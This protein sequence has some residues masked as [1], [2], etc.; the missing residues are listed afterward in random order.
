MTG[1]A[2]KRND[3]QSFKS[4][5]LHE[6]V[7][8]RVSE[9][10][11]QYPA[12]E[13][14]APEV[15]VD[16]G[17]EMKTEIPASSAA[18]AA[19]SPSLAVSQSDPASAQF[20]VKEKIGEGGMG[21][22]YKAE[23]SNNGNSVAVKMLHTNLVSDK[24][25]LRRFE[26]EAAAIGQLTH[27]NIVQVYGF[28][29][30]KD[31]PHL[32]MEY[33][34]GC[35]LAEI[36]RHDRTVSVPRVI[37]W[38]IQICSA[39]KHAHEKGIVHRDLKPSNIL[40]KE[41]SSG[42]Q[43]KLVDFG[44]AKLIP[45]NGS[46]TELTQTGEVFG[47]PNY[48][49]PEQCMGKPV[50]ARTDIYS[51]GCI[52]YEAL[53]GKNLFA[54]D[55]SVQYLIHH[56]NSP[57]A[58]QLANLRKFGAPASL[59]AVLEKMLQKDP[60]KRYQT[61]AEVEEEFK[62]LAAGKSSAAAQNQLLGRVAVAG[63]AVAV[64]AIGSFGASKLPTAPG[65]GNAA[66]L[67]TSSKPQFGIF[68][69]SAEAKLQRLVQAHKDNWAYLTGPGRHDRS[70][71]DRHNQEY[72]ELSE[73]LRRE[74]S[75]MGPAAIPALL[76]YVTDR[77][78]SNDVNGILMEIGK[79]AVQPSID[80][81]RSHPR[82]YPKIAN[83]FWKIGKPACDRLAEM[84]VSNP[85]DRALAAS[86]L[87]SRFNRDHRFDGVFIGPSGRTEKVISS[88]SQKSLVEAL[89]VEKDNEVRTNLIL[90]LRNVEEPSATTCD[91]LIKL[92]KSES[93]EDAKAAA[94]GTM[95]YWANRVSGEVSTRLTTALAKILM[96]D[97]A[98]DARIAAA[99]GLGSVTRTTPEIIAALRGAK[100][101]PSDSVHQAAVV[102]L[103]KLALYDD[104]LLPDLID[105]LK[106]SSRQSVAAALSTVRQLG[107]KAVG[108]VSAI[109]KVRP[110]NGNWQVIE[111][112]AATQSDTKEVQEMML[113]VLEQT[114][115]MRDFVQRRSAI[116]YFKSLGE[117]G[118]LAVPVL[119]RLAES[120]RS[121]N[122]YEAR[123]ALKA[124]TG[125]IVQN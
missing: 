52:I 123:E 81:L 46:V 113:S 65:S 73:R 40:I 95:A 64:V 47:S 125:E 15:F 23:L 71:R 55:N 110:T 22:V 87:A 16:S 19:I 26:K 62:K 56:I 99:E 102:A 79:P 114:D 105:A 86:I 29:A 88:S 31:N 101:D 48:M 120:G 37:D 89:N 59:V 41:S 118:K 92:A 44:I 21:A 33:V 109:L 1:D 85:Q 108:A 76:Q 91:A 70:D 122:R 5:E 72:R 69:D 116:N 54:A 10:E 49:S 80:W 3:A 107:P 9:S 39:I 32:V 12:P 24:V 18:A 68:G 42:D 61:A 96:H 115:E 13:P 11:A 17:T 2:D 66:V 93:N 43:I 98:A 57:V 51:L 117:R 119:K 75:D 14:A 58:K 27:P 45:Q 36:L 50:D 28:A 112:L 60:Q 34:D 4:P 35:S 77:D 84:T 121:A 7:K 103:S 78:V 8:L 106:E 63:A 111:A 124:I 25:A 38:T 30:D 6:E 83:V 53:S 20:S 104:S 82:D 94:A 97:D 74:L 90:A 67:T 100:K